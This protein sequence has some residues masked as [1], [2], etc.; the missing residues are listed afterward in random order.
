MTRRTAKLD[1]SF[2][3]DFRILY[4]RQNSKS[5]ASHFA[6][7]EVLQFLRSLCC[8]FLK[9]AEREQFFRSPFDP[10]LAEHLVLKLFE[11]RLFQRK[12][13]EDLSGFPQCQWEIVALRECGLSFQAQ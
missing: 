7:I 13:Q 11:L 10:L 5:T 8:R 2:P 12:Y 6:E 4:R 1:C 9:A 3:V